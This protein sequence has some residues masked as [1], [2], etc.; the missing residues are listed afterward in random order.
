MKRSNAEVLKDAIELYSGLEFDDMLTQE[1]WALGELMDDIKI[2]Y[3]IIDLTIQLDK[4]NMSVDDCLLID[5]SF[6]I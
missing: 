1:N 2:N 6:C 3:C 4:F 5:D